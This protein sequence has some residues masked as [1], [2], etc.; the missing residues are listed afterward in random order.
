MSFLVKPMAFCSVPASFSYFEKR[1]PMKIFNI[2]LL[3]YAK[4]LEKFDLIIKGFTITI[5]KYMKLD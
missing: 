4:F 3:K 5:V 1:T 2:K